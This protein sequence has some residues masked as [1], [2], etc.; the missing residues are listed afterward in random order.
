MGIALHDEG[1]D[2]A[3]DGQGLDHGEAHEEH[4]LQDALGLGLAGHMAMMVA[5]GL[6]AYLATEVGGIV[7]IGGSVFGIVLGLFIY[8]L[9]LLIQVLQAYIFTLLFAVY[10]QGALQEGH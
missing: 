1:E 6:T 10:V 8:F 9:E 4:G 2:Q 3:Q 5:A 7:G